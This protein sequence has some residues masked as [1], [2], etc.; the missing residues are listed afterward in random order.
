M[1]CATATPETLC[2]ATFEFS[3]LLLSSLDGVILRPQ[4]PNI[5]KDLQHLPFVGRGYI[6]HSIDGREP[7]G[8]R[9]MSAVS[10]QLPHASAWVMLGTCPET[11]CTPYS[12]IVAERIDSLPNGGGR[13]DR[14]TD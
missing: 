3:F 13:T 2:R 14:R 9:Y 10:M 12:Y 8:K 7:T 6:S 1:Q 11:P 5:S 4:R